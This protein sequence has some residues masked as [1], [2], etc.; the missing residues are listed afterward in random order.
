MPVTTIVV[1]TILLAILIIAVIVFLMRVY[2]KPLVES[3]SEDDY[4]KQISI[5]LLIEAVF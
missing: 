4:W 5:I 3:F 2:V 1:S